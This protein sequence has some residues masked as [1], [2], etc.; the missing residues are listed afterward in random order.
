MPVSDARPECKARTLLQ[1]GRLRAPHWRVWRARQNWPP[2]FSGARFGRMVF[3]KRFERQHSEADATRPESRRATQEPDSPAVRFDLRVIVYSFPS[4]NTWVR[5]ASSAL[6]AS[7]QFTF[8]KPNA[9]ERAG[10]GA[11]PRAR[12]RLLLR[13]GLFRLTLGG[14]FV[15]YRLFAVAVGFALHPVIDRR[16]H[17]VSSYKI[18]GVLH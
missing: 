16:Q 3:S 7:T 10:S 14:Q 9:R 12:L 5:I 8:N 6:L 17:H 13:S 2:R 11:Y 15:D 4:E 18:G 1:D